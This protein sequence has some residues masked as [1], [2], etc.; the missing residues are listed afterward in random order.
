MK[1]FMEGAFVPQPG[2][3]VKD[4]KAINARIKAENKEIGIHEISQEELDEVSGWSD[5]KLEAY[6]QTIADEQDKRR[7]KASN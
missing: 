2:E 4:D 3:G 6:A 5:K 1:N 7:K